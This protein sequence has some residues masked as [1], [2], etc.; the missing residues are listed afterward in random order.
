M[1]WLKTPNGKLFTY[2]GIVF[3]GYITGLKDIQYDT[4]VTYHWWDWLLL[5]SGLGMQ[6]FAVVKAFGANPNS[7]DVP[8]EPSKT[9]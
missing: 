6:V 4:V 9:P 8:A 1:N 3:F 5:A 7:P 2:I